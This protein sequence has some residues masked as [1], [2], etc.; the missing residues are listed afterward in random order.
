MAESTT[1]TSDNEPPNQERHVRSSASPAPN[2]TNGAGI[3]P[4]TPVESA[5]DTQPTETGWRR[6]FS[7]LKYREFR[8]LW[9]GMLFLMTAMQMQMVVRG[10]L[11][12]ELT[13]SPLRLGLVSAGF[14]IPMLTLALFGGAVADRME[15]K[16]VIQPVFPRWTESLQRRNNPRCPHFMVEHRSCQLP[17]NIL[18]A[19]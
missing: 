9:L 3:T 16:R 18:N 19:T 10:Y 5:P 8:F 13:D 15:R 4:P 12:Y 17:P 1:G 6:T 14:A 7:S 2:S 11:T